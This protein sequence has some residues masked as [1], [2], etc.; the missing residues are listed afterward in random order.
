M[1][2]RAIG[3]GGRGVGRMK[4][5]LMAALRGL[6]RRHVMRRGEFEGAGGQVSGGG[7]VGRRLHEGVDH[8][9]GEERSGVRRG[10]NFDGLGGGVDGRN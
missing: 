10:H 8:G 3:R 5:R 6:G 2:R 4:R 1:P 9:R 7:G